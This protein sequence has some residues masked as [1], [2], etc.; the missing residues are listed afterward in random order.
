MNGPLGFKAAPG[1]SSYLPLWQATT[2][3][4]CFEAKTAAE[5][6]TDHQKNERD[7]SE[8]LNGML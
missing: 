7:N 2:K 1:R 6:V 4:I 5:G 8:K 3:Q